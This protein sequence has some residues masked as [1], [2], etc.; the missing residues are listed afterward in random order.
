LKLEGAHY[1]GDGLS[2]EPR[3]QTS[4]PLL[5]LWPLPQ[6][7]ALRHRHHSNDGGLP[8]FFRLVLHLPRRGRRGPQGRHRQHHGMCDSRGSSGLSR[9][10]PDESGHLRVREQETAE[11]GGGSGPRRSS[12]RCCRRRWHWASSERLAGMGGRSR[13]GATGGGRR[14]IC[15]RSVSG[16]PGGGGR[17][18][19]VEGNR[20]CV[21]R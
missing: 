1:L 4:R 12:S 20:E 6:P 13:R 2:A 8:R 18:R 7:E 5:P 9:S 10:A 15:W 17:R 3:R 21:I 16:E 11:G 19:C 14:W